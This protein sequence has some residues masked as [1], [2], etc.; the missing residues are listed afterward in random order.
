MQP[1][2][3]RAAAGR[4]AALGWHRHLSGPHVADFDGTA[5]IPQLALDLLGEHYGRAGHVQVHDPHQDARPFV[6]Q[7]LDETGDPALDTERWDDRTTPGK[8]LRKPPGRFI[9]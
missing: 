9:R 4:D 2:A 8:I 7:A 6:S 5:G 1:R 3:R